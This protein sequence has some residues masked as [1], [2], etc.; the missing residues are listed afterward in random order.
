MGLFDDI[1]DDLCPSSLRIPPLQDPFPFP[2]T[3]DQRPSPLEPNARTNSN[4]DKE[5]A[6]LT[7]RGKALAEAKPIGETENN[8]LRPIHSTPR[9]RQKKYDAKQMP[10]FVQLPRP[11]AK[12]QD[13]NPRP[14]LPI[15]VLNALHEPPPS[16]AL[17]PPITPSASQVDRDHRLSEGS[18]SGP[19]AEENNEEHR[20]ESLGKDNTEKAGSPK[21]LYLRKR[22]KWSEVETRNLIKGIDKFGVGKWT[23]ILNDPDYY[24]SEGRN[25]ID[26]KDRF[27][28]LMGNPPAQPLEGGSYQQLLGY[29]DG[30]RNRKL[31]RQSQKDELQQSKRKPK[32][33]W[34]EEED[35]SLVEG[36][37]KHGFCWKDIA[38]D[39]TLALENR[40][41]TQIRD[42]FRK[43]FPELYGEAPA[44]SKDSQ[45]V[46]N[47]A[48]TTPEPKVKQ[49]L[50]TGQHLVAG[51]EEEK[52]NGEKSRKTSASRS[53]QAA[54]TSGPHDI[55]GLLNNDSGDTR[56]T[57]F[58][59]DD[60]AENVT[61]AP[62]LWED[63]CTKP[64]FELD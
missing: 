63:L 2:T 51:G 57:N 25:A 31:E 22:S 40:T 37:Q 44:P 6:K 36:Y 8:E 15:S 56:Q 1:F 28:T 52:R 27:R 58:R 35:E 11:K 18:L 20:G 29:V 10:D 33:L 45:H 48:A 62:L 47:G 39:S 61:L 49:P 3:T 14:F 5:A 24:F 30:P 4:F 55:N 46:S 7:G 19:A 59:S 53:R 60:W 43:R 34:S 41:G 38:N 17:F 12:V 9:K 32:H 54:L 13:E 50:A 64:M 42:R 23:K 16:A 26:L 21:R